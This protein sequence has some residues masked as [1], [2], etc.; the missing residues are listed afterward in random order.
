MRGVTSVLRDKEGRVVLRLYLNETGSEY[1]EVSMKPE[2][3][4]SLGTDLLVGART[5]AY[6]PTSKVVD[7]PDA[8]FLYVDRPSYLGPQ[9][10]LLRPRVPPIPPA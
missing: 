2:E 8:T 4:V 6:Y 5:T 7:S 1:Y 3:A 10:S 9:S